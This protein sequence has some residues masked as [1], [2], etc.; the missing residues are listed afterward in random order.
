MYDLLSNS[1]D[2]FNFR[3]RNNAASLREDKLGNI[4]MCG[5]KEERIET[6]Q[7]LFI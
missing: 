3:N 1:G 4:L 2:P 6:E 7:E 5:V